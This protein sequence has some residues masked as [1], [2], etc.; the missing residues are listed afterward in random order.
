MK[1]I[2]ALALA[3]TSL[4][5][6]L[7]PGADDAPSGPSVVSTDLNGDTWTTVDDTAGTDGLGL[8]YLGVE[9]APNGHIWAVGQR[10]EAGD[11]TQWVVRESTN[12]GASFG[13]NS[14]VGFTG[15]F[16]AA[17]AVSTDSAGRIFVSGWGLDA[18]NTSHWIT[19]RSTNDGATWTIVDDWSPS[20]ASASATSISIDSND[21]IFVGGGGDDSNSHT[22][23]K[24]RFSTDHGA[25]WQQEDFVDRG[26]DDGI[27]GG[28]LGLCLNHS[29]LWSVGSRPIA[30]DTDGL[31]VRDSSTATDKVINN[32]AWQANGCGGH[33]G[34]DP[35][36]VAGQTVPQPSFDAHWIVSRSV[37][38][39]TFVR[40]DDLSTGNNN[41]DLTAA[42]AVH[43]GESGTIF[44]AG[45]V[46]RQWRVRK[47]P[48]GTT[49][50][51]SDKFTL[52]GETSSDISQAQAFQF[53]SSLGHTY[54]VGFATVNGVE[55]G[56]I[57]RN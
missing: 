34:T 44:A 16:G 40:V 51:D 14:A 15:G 42:F 20:G 4:V 33:G 12:G 11:N 30:H 49:W 28:V 21:T 32:D 13:F 18:N 53:S 55:H 27:G 9:V 5:G 38:G 39:G 6:C 37:G 23:W 1:P 50:E 46:G 43:A 57:R 29:D 52:S 35:L 3:S 26:P 8:L 56:I 36:Y 45:I 19:E 10:T 41:D 54:V 24:V 47:T 2:L 22:F 17:E 48:D 31:V 7:D 25:T